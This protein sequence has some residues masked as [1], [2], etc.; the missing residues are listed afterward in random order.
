MIDKKKLKEEYKNMVPP[1]GVFAFRN[2][3]TGKVF[4][5]SSLNLK[6]KD[7]TLKMMLKVGNH[8]NRALQE[9]W[10][11]YGEESF[12]YEILEQLELN[13]DPTY[14]YNEELEILEMLWIDKFQPFL[15]KCYN[16]KE[17]IRLV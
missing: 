7:A 11:K 13:E 14:N 12:E 2:T 3:K 9:D 17:K 10:N 4:L 8:F 16:T 6:N 5:G 15:E 1:K